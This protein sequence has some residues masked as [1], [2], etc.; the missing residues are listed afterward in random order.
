MQSTQAT[1]PPHLAGIKRAVKQMAMKRQ[2]PLS[3]LWEKGAGAV[4][5]Y[6]NLAVDTGDNPMLNKVALL[7]PPPSNGPE[8]VGVCARK[9]GGPDITRHTDGPREPIKLHPPIPSYAYT[10]KEPGPLPHGA[11]QT[12]TREAILES[13]DT[14]Y[15]RKRL[16]ATATATASRTRQRRTQ[17]GKRRK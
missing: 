4:L 7:L 2:S 9:R 12:P 13:S 11:K 10:I 5:F 14:P 16:E 1:Q 8:T 3:R 6:T 17:E 15:H